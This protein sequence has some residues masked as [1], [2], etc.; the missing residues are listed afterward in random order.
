[1]NSHLLLSQSHVD[2][3]GHFAVARSSWERY[4]LNW[5]VQLR[6]WLVRWAVRGGDV[7]K[8]AFD[9]A[10]SL[11]F[12]LV[13]SPLYLALALLVKLNDRGP[14]F[15]SQTRVGRYGKTFQMYKFRSMRLNAEAEFQKLLAQNQHA[16]GVTFKMKNDPRVTS[17]GKWLRRFSLDE[18]PQFVN[19]LKGEMSLVGPRPP[20][21]REVA[22]YTL[23]DRRRLAVKP[24]LTCFWQVSGRS[25]IDFSGQVKLDV[26]YIETAGFWVDIKILAR[27]VSAVMAGDGAS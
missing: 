18:L 11:A 13:F 12:L 16:E 8:R 10:G 21:P 23:A 14:V 22:L 2:T 20:V 27:T 17:V 25:N 3:F 6:R 1:M 4:W 5:N 7:G 19:V 24:G 26:R 15:F 9:I